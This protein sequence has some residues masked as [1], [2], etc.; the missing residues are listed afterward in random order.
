MTQLSMQESQRTGGTILK[1]LYLFKMYVLGF[2]P[3][4]P[5]EPI[6]LKLEIGNHIFLEQAKL[7]FIYHLG[8]FYFN[9]KVLPPLCFFSWEYFVISTTI[10]L[11]LMGNSLF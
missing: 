1:L 2:H 4:P 7:G 10:K 3:R 6:F 9:T 11:H 5:T 8:T